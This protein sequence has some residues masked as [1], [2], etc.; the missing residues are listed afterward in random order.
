MKDT[1]FSKSKDF[2]QEYSATIIKVGE[3]NDIENS[4]NLKQVII[5]GF[6]VV[7]NKND[8][9]AG[10]YMIYCKNETAINSTFLSINNMYDIGNYILNENSDEVQKLIESGKQCDVKNMVGYFNKHGRVKLIKLRGCP[11]M[12]VLLHFNNFI[13]WNE[14]LSGVKLE[15][16]ITYDTNG[17]F[18]PFDFD[19]VYDE[20]FIKAY[21]PKTNVKNEKVGEKNKE[22]KANKFN[23]IIDGEF[24]FHYDTGQLNS[25][26]WKLTPEQEVYISTKIHG[27]SIC[28]G[29]ILV[30]KLTI[31]NKFRDF[32]NSFKNKKIRKYKK[33]LD[34][35]TDSYLRNKFAKKVSVLE[36]KKIH[37]FDTE[38]C[39]IY[40]SRCVIKNKY[41]NKN[42]T[43]GFYETDIWGEYEK[44][45]EGK[46]PQNVTIYGEIVGYLTGSEKMIQKNYDYGCYKGTNKLMIYRVNEKLPDGTHK[47]Y[48]ISDVIKFIQDLKTVYPEIGDKLMP[49]TLLYHGKLTNLYPNV[50]VDNTWNYKILELLKRDKEHFCMELD[51]PLCKNKVPREGICL[52]IANDK[53]VECFKLK[54]LYF[55]GKEAEQI[56]KGEVDIEMIDSFN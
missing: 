31:M 11:S 5:D 25:N 47:E 46:I 55:L 9:K 54:C 27:T 7:V 16:Y 21:I 4:D 24:S 48:E 51:E 32:L 3:L 40:S 12:G 34:N 49:F 30:K 28:M 35:T 20:L 41:I 1:V 19:T 53:N 2:K 29:N 43:N 26:M 56:D 15:D 23:R 37:K 42:V 50:P 8:I 13:K 36:S 33:L 44:L 38:Y 39:D 17:N 18:I 52:R 14:K 45:L 10:D 6:S 22:K